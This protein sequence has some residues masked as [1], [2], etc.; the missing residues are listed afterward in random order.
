MERKDEGCKDCAMIGRRNFLQ[1]AGRA[2]GGA[3][4]GLFAACSGGTLA[5]GPSGETPEG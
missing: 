4:V 3:S 1:L 2:A 5:K